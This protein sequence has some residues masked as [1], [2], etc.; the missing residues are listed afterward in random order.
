M[1]GVPGIT[2]GVYSLTALLQALS[3]RKMHIA[4]PTNTTKLSPDT[5]DSPAMRSAGRELLSLALMDAR[6]HTLQLLTRH[7]DVLAGQDDGLDPD[8]AAFPS[9]ETQ[10]PVSSASPLWLA[11][12]AGWFFLPDNESAFPFSA[13]ERPGCGDF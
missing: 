7:E 3:S 12:H 6:N 10:T 9:A 13:A 4:M 2:P 5:I 8:D 1:Q 11:G